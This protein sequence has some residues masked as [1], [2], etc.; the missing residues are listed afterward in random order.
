MPSTFEWVHIIPGVKDLPVH[1][2]HTMIVM[3]FLVPLVWAVGR[4]LSDPNLDVVPPRRFGA[5]TFF[6]MAYEAIHGLATG[7]L[8]HHARHFMYLL[9]GLAVYILF[10]NLLGVIPGLAPPTDNINT[11]AACAITVFF[12][13][14]WYGFKHQGA[15]YLKH[16]VGPVAWLAPLMIPIEI[17][18]HL[19]RPLSLSLR[20]FG[21]MFGDHIV[22][23]VFTFMTISL[24]TFL[25]DGAAWLKI[26]TPISVVIPFVVIVL[27]IFVAVV[28]TLVFLLLTMSYLAGSVADHH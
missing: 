25:L 13:T 27:G 1:L 14:H 19:A 2:S 9:G 12:L 24:T 7:V 6:E 26:F 23:T 10:S 16:F 20:L 28:Q 15:A 17:I 3:L 21:N 22:L 4:K 8:G 18:G 11:T 5:F